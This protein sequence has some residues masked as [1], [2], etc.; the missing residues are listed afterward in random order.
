MRFVFIVVSTVVDFLLSVS[1]VI[2]FFSSEDGIR[3]GGSV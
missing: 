2:L 1:F 3:Y